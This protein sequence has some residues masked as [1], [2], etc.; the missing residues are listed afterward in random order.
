MDPLI[1]STG[2]H[3]SPEDPRD[4]TLASVGAPTTYPDACSIDQSFM[5]VSMQGQIGCC[6]G[7]TFEEIIRFMVHAQTGVQLDLSWRFVY[8]VCKS[9]EGTPG[10]EQF[11]PSSEGTYPA[12]AAIVIRKFGVPLA[13]LCPNNVTLDH[14]SFV[15][16]RSLA[17]IPSAA[18][19]DA[20][21][22]KGGAD[23]AVPVSIDGIKQ[24]ITYAQA[25]KGGVAILRQVGDSYWS[26][27]GVNTWDKAK[28]L[29]ITPPNPILSGHEEFL[30]G[31][32][33]ITDAEA[34]ALA[35]KEITIESLIAKY[36][37]K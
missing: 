19:A 34:L 14:E 7:C 11:V 21:T 4:W 36:G 8:A 26:V 31:Y 30:Y 5:N 27:N 28:L 9:L 1:L 32:M 35:N 6:V 17:N 2:A 23:F 20:L 24:A 3:V 10:Y 16:Q 18:I 15:Y 12:L 33:D 37:N 29:P 22:R 25:N 13:S